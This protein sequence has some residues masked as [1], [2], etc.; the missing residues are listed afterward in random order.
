L[1]SV[2]SHAR[3]KNGYLLLYQSLINHQVEEEQG[4][5][6]REEKKKTGKE[7]KERERKIDSFFF[8]F[9]SIILVTCPTHTLYSAGPIIYSEIKTND[10]FLLLYLLFFCR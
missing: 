8:F 10:F 7:K 2:D 3:N 1:L 9:C 5:R 6:R 4:P